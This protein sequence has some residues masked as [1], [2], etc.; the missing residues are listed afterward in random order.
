MLWRE[1][2]GQALRVRQLISRL[3]HAA[4]ARAMILWKEVGEDVARQKK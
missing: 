2:A 1:H 4:E 3:R